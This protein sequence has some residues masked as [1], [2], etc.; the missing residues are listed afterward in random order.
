VTLA[1]LCPDGNTAEV[2]QR[3][4]DVLRAV[5]VTQAGE[6]DGVWRTVLPDWFVAACSSEGVAGDDPDG[7]WQLEA[8]LSWF[9]NPEFALERPWY[10]W[11]GSVVDPK[12]YGSSSTSR[13][14]RFRSMRC[15]GWSSLPVP[16]NYRKRADT[17]CSVFRHN[18]AVP[19][20]PFDEPR[21]TRIRAAREPLSWATVEMSGSA[22]CSP[23]RTREAQ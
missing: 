14:G 22:S 9:V 4:T 21:H 18:S 23:S 1:A 8:W 7:P 16:S 6:D 13:D 19:L 10:W 12:H 17:V 15:D 3:C 2:E 20:C 5:L 11:R